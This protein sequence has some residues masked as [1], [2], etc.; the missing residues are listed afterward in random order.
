VVP[1]KIL[2]DVDGGTLRPPKVPDDWGQ[3]GR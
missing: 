1:K 3:T 2:S